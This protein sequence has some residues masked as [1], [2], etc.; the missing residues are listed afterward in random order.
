MVA[1]KRRKKSFSYVLYVMYVLL[2]L[3]IIGDIIGASLYIKLEQSSQSL[4]VSYVNENI[5]AFDQAQWSFN[6]LF[7]KQFMYQGSMWVLG[8]TVI[9]VV[10]NLFLVFLKGV[11]AGFNIFFIFQTLTP[12]D[13]ILTSFLWLMQYVLILGVTIL[14]GYFSIR[15]VI[16]IVKIIFFKKNTTILQ[17]HLLYYFYQLVIIMILTLITSG[18][19]YLIQPLVYHQFEKAGQTEQVEQAADDFIST[20]SDAVSNLMLQ[21]NVNFEREML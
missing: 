16:M 19:T 21:I 14:S 20:S 5:N 11:I 8:L 6:Q 13:A 18:V 12:L 2:L 17:K 1:Q 10:V 3:V 15:F 7:Y 4:M 9:G